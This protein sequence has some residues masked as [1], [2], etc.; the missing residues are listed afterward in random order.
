MVQNTF[1]LHS[2][3]IIN[4]PF[5]AKYSAPRQPAT[6]KK[7]TIGVITLHERQNFEQ[8]L[9][10]LQGF[11]YIW[12]IFLFHKNKNWKPKVL[13]PYGG[14]IKRGVF[15]TRSPHRP[16]PIGLS[17]CRLIDVRGRIVRIENPDM[18]DET[19][20]LD[21]KPYIP[22]AES[23]P[24]ARSGWIDD[25]NEQSSPLFTVSYAPG[26]QKT[27]GTLEK[28]KSSEL[29]AYVTGIL[30]RNPYPHPYRRIKV[31]NNGTSILAVQRWRFTFEIKGKAITVLK[32]TLASDE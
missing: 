13:P 29:A 26:A 30:S 3:G 17:L 27:L 1:S 21:I 15:A 32:M 4:T 8:G 5:K 31:M 18:L 25:S 22:H 14:N 10:D 9:E 19:P 28:E 6:A 2:I 7:R 23:I 24:D 12:V 20:V 16:N 11:D